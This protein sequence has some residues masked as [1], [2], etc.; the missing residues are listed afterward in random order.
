METAAPNPAPFGVVILPSFNSGPKLLETLT[1]ARR[2]WQ[3]VWVVID[4][5]TDGSDR[6]VAEY[7]R[8]EE[9]VEVIRRATN[10]GKGQAVL[11][12]LRRAR[13]AGI[14]RA[15]VMDA[16]GQHPA[17]AIEKFFELARQNPDALIL[18][19]PVFD[20]D[21]P[22]LRVYG[23]LFGNFFTRLNTGWANVADSLFGFRVYP[24]SETVAIMDQIRTA[25][26]Y[27]F[28]TE[29]VVRLVWAGFRP[30]NQRVPVRYFTAAEGGSSYF[31]YARDNA[32]LIRTHVRLFFGM[33][34]RLPRLLAQKRKEPGV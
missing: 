27:D 4:G 30:L 18:G 34:G 13:D 20:A 16:D 33:M 11:D 15:L 23:R 8:S 31:R 9:G 29:I 21:A 14:A 28:D 24:V 32:L 7:A 10:G 3:P 1:A 17:E 5:S 12:A 26:R 22:A 25:R 19:C 6:L 2:A